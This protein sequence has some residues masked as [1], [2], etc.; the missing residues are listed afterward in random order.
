MGPKA[1]HEYAK[2]I[3][4]RYVWARK[5]ERSALLTEFT[6]VTGYHRKY[7]IMLLSRAPIRG[8]KRR[9]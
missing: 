1:C 8:R 4:R 7:A 3:R 5:S 6:A 2:E 9:S